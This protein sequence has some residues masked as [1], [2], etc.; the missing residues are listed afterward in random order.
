MAAGEMLMEVAGTERPMRS[1]PHH[2]VKQQ[3][4]E[5]L[6]FGRETGAPTIALGKHGECAMHPGTRIPNNVKDEQKP[7]FSVTANSSHLIDIHPRSIDWN[8]EEKTDVS[9]PKRL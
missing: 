4:L 7:V 5:K 6:R 2:L 3:R 1:A 9:R 8:Y